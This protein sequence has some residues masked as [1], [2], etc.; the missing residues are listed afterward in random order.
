MW[1]NEVKCN[2]SSAELSQAR[3]VTRVR[4]VLASAYRRAATVCERGVDLPSATINIEYTYTACVALRTVTRYPRL[5]SPTMSTLNRFSDAFVKVTFQ[6][7]PRHGDP[8]AE[9]WHELGMSWLQRCEAPCL[10]PL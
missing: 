4:R 1:W 8:M 6:E 3:Q 7:E 9:P 2:A 5:P 10:I